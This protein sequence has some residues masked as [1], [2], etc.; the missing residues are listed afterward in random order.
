MSGTNCHL[1]LGSLNVIPPRTLPKRI[2]LGAVAALVVVY[3]GDYLY[4]RVRQLHPKSADPFES[5]KALRVLAIPEKNGK[6]SYEVDTQN[7]EQTVTCVHSLFPHH[8]YSPC[9][10]VKPRI[11][12]PIPM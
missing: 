6:T 3:I 11:N 9:W 10:Y 7:P 4:V 5:I 1:C 12:Q 2:L 8:G